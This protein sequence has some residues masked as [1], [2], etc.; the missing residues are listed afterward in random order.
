MDW[1]T[2]IATIAFLALVILQAKMNEDTSQDSQ[3]KKASVNSSVLHRNQASLP[4]KH[5]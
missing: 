1:K 5:K 2:V 4:T 3:V